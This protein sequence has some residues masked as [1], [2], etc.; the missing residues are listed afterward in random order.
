MRKLTKSGSFSMS[1]ENMEEDTV[2]DAIQFLL[3]RFPAEVVFVTKDLTL[4]SERLTT[5]PKILTQVGA[6]FRLHDQV[7]DKTSAH[8][9]SLRLDSRTSPT[10]HCNSSRSSR[11]A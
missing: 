5:F 7:L 1:A 3:D 9:A 8:P 6:L 11:L 4:S 2:P 10:L